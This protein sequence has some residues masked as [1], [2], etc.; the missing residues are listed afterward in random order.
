MLEGVK[1]VHTAVIEAEL[2]ELVD[3]KVSV[4]QCLEILENFFVDAEAA[5]SLPGEIGGMVA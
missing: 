3:A 5:S 1:A 2:K 4:S